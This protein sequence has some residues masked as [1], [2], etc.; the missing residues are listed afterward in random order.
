[1]NSQDYLVSLNIPLILEESM[2]DCLLSFE[3]ELSFSRLQINVHDPQHKNL[4]LAEQVN[5]RQKKIHFQLLIDQPNLSL[6]LDKLKAKFS[7]TGIEYW[8]SPVVEQGYI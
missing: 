8:I 1:M 7:G 4:S 3:P 2:E 6:L 5:G